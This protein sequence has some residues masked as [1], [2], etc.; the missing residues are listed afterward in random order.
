MSGMTINSNLNAV[1]AQNQISQTSGSLNASLEKLASAVRINSA[2]DDPAGLAISEGLS[3]QVRGASQALQNVQD[4]IS[5][6]QTAEGG[7]K[8]V[9]DNLQR[10]RELSV[11]ASND[12]LTSDQREIINEEVSQLKEQINKVTDQVEFNGKKLLNGDISSGSGGA[13][14]QSGA[15]SGETVEV[16]AEAQDTSS[17]GVDGSDVTTRSSAEQAIES[18]TGAIN[19]VATERAS[20]GAQQN[21]L[22][23]TTEFLRVSREN[24]IASES[25]IRDADVAQATTERVQS[26]IL[27][28]SGTSVLS[29]A[30]NLQG[31]RALQLLG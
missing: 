13:Q 28:Q 26:S 31:Q 3:S 8:Q 17:L 4:G 12:S 14:I 19:Q 5:M 30:N 11:R 27:T 23:G 21:R 18:T 10:I 24:Q 9:T 22:E 7:M 20:L 6:I 25:R 29:Q 15:D 2:S 16:S 1:R